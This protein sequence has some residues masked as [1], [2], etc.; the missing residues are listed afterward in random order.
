V[1][2]LGRALFQHKVAMSAAVPSQ[3]EGFP[4]PAFRPP[5]GLPPPSVPMLPGLALNLSSLWRAPPAKAGAS[6][7]CN[8]T[9][10]GS[11]GPP[12]PSSESSY[13]ACP[14]RVGGYV[15]GE[16]LRKEMMQDRA[17]ALQLSLDDVVERT[18]C[19][20]ADCPSVGSAGHWVGMCQ[21][22]DFVHRGLC[23][24]GA[25]CKYCHLCTP[26]ARNLRRKQRKALLKAGRRLQISGSAVQQ[27]AA[28]PGTEIRTARSP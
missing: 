23:T 13:I 21:P 9:S 2:N 8:S 5:P 15:P 25:A 10:A 22:C 16:A 12:S 26:E 20:T 3:S 18:T 1:A 11:S 14:A 24:N 7:C 19:G 4:G 27:P 28:V 17:P 6:D